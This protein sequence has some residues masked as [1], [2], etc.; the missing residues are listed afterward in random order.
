M[1]VLVGRMSI[2]SPF[3]GFQ[4]N[5]EF[6]VLRAGKDLFILF[7]VVFFAQLVYNLT[8]LY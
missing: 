6:A 4:S 2:K 5:Q 7:I 8:G 1:R 3:L